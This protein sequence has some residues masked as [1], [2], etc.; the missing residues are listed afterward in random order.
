MIVIT[1]NLCLIIEKHVILKTWDEVP[2]K[3]FKWNRTGSAYF[4]NQHFMER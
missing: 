4:E 1:I 2:R 3:G